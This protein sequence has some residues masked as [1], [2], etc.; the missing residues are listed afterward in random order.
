MISITPCI[1]ISPA[2]PTATTRT[3]TDSRDV[4]TALRDGYVYQGQYSEYRRPPARP[5]ARGRRARINWWCARK[6]T[7]KS[8]I[9]RR[10][11]G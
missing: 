1:V 8:A 5:A 3:F 6:I 4:A 9:A 11:S 2:R 7:I 10:A